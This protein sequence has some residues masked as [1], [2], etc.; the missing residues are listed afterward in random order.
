MPGV[1]LTGTDSD[2]RDIR[3]RVKRLS[4]IGKNEPELVEWSHILGRVL[5]R[6]VAVFDGNNEKDWWNGIVNYKRG[7][8]GPSYL[9]GWILAFCPW[10]KDG[11]YILKDPL[12]ENGSYGRINT[13]H[14]PSST[15]EVPVLIDDN[16]K[17]YRVIFYAGN[18][19]CRVKPA[20]SQDYNY[21]SIASVQDWALIDIT[22][23]ISQ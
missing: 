10:K 8:S 9:S 12:K 19:H 21:L 3:M 2:W 18:I 20:I 13:L 17:K 23:E 11:T 4:E 6:F 14:V 5:D 1:T 15:V 22:K 16:G 7:M